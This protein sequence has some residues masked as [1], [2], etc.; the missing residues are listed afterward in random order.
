MSAHITVMGL[1][2]SLPAASGSAALACGAADHGV[3]LTDAKPILRIVKGMDDPAKCC[4]LCLADEGCA[5]WNT[6]SNMKQCFLRAVYLASKGNQSQ[7]ISGRMAGRTPAPAP[8]QKSCMPTSG[9][10]GSRPITASSATGVGTP[11]VGGHLVPK[12]YP[13]R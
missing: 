7:C 11:P 3:C 13:G 9:R 10:A 1:L 2:V 12:P 8:L 6:N 4:A 5:A